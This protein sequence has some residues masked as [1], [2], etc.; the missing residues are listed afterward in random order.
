MQSSDCRLLC[1]QEAS[2]ICAPWGDLNDHEII[3]ALSEAYNKIAH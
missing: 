3:N 1:F 2:T